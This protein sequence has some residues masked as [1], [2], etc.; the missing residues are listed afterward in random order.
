MH[1]G[2][3]IKRVLW[4]IAGT[5]VL[6]V[7]AAVYFTIRY[8][9]EIIRLFIAEANKHILTPV[10]VKNVEF[11]MFRQFP[12]VTISLRDVEMDEGFKGSKRK[13]LRAGSLRFTFSLWDIL[14]K[15]YSVQDIR[16]EKGA[17]LVRYDAEGN[18][19]YKVL[20]G[21]SGNKQ[22]FFNLEN[23][24]LKDVQL[25]YEHNKTGLMIDA[26]TPL[27]KLKI[28]GAD[29]RLYFD[30]SGQLNTG[31]IKVKGKS[32][33]KN[34][35]VQF[36]T[37]IEYLQGE[38]ITQFENGELDID[39]ALF[40]V[41]G[42]VKSSE[43]TLHLVIKGRNT[44]FNTLL[45]LLPEEYAK[46][47]RRYKTRGKVYFNALL[48]GR[49][50]LNHGLNV[51]VSFGSANASFYHP[52]F[53]KG[54]EKVRF[55]GKFLNG[56]KNRSK[57][58]E[59]RLDDFSCRLD[60]RHVTGNLLIRNFDDYYL[61]FNVKGLIDVQSLLDIF[62]NK[63]V[64]SAYGRMN[65]DL[66]GEG[67]L[68]DLNDPK[69]RNQFNTDGEVDLQNV[70]FIL[71]GERLPF[72]A[73]NGSFIF[74]KND[75]AI[76]DF[77][78]KVGSSDFKL[79]GFFKYITNWLFAK[80]QKISIDADLYSDF[81]DFDEL[82]KSNFA[83]RDTTRQQDKKYQFRISPDLKIRF[84]CIISKVRF[85]RFTGR[86]I[87][88]NLSINDRIATFNDIRFRSIGGTARL[89]GSVSNKDDN[90]VEVITD[91]D[92]NGISIDSL[93]YMFNNFN[94]NWIVDRNLRG[95]ITASLN[96]YLRFNRY[97]K[98]NTRSLI[99]DIHAIVN[100]G[101]L[102]EFEP[103]QRLSTFI[104]SET[105]SHLKFSSMQNDIRI[106]D[107]TIFIPEM[108]VRTNVSDITISGTHTFDQRIDYHLAVPL[109]LFLNEGRKKR[110]AEDAVDGG[111]L[112]LSIK[113]TT[114][115]YKVSYD[116][117]ALAK[118]IKN[119]ISNEGKEWRDILH[120]KGSVDTTQKA[121][122][123]LEEEEYFD[124][125]EEEDKDGGGYLP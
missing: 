103:A 81:L 114:S 13:L 125:D 76:S 12:D 77:T 53:K 48:D 21:R 70:S 121:E 118:S 46:P 90:R 45:S 75:L 25:H 102:V 112:L 79:N 74:N 40:S 105:L 47:Y 85:R 88:G 7:S 60:G 6:A 17:V 111:K 42:D 116:T 99:A 15:R 119:E 4:I 63:V 100:N 109:M 124:F 71:Y 27:S 49:Y 24:V 31:Y 2:R 89:S 117:R 106:A 35:H 59:L 120:K 30:L 82:L 23:I 86:D 64:R 96:T 18:P 52:K 56:Q 66:R 36:N 91:V 32:Y 93:F 22:T 57:T 94:Q 50:D 5:I 29:N 54:L 73:F 122:P 115:D 19:N 43:K 8:Q 95:Q 28:R 44:T 37:K 55:E 33:L 34:K 123:I 51:D 110:F 58:F 108:D 9:D 65:M 62:P 10:D 14:H 68:S 1:F 3:K 84:N 72:N 61:K 80:N 41:T 92:L 87:R 104:E 11:S 113:G 38:K 78:G 101:E 20:S 16:V 83:S 107:E 97:M 67:R 69:K 39:G 98:L 26:F